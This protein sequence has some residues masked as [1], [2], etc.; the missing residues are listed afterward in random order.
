MSVTPSS[1]V[2]PIIRRALQSFGRARTAIAA[3]QV[4][5]M[6]RHLTQGADLLEA[7]DQGVRRAAR[8]SPRKSAS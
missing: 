4:D 8:R 2:T 7:I 6:I 5:K 1:A 3:G